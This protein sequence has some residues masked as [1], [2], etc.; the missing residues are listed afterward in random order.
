MDVL[1]V[2]P[3][4]PHNTGC[5]ARLAA[6]TGVA[7]HL[8]EPL[9]FSLEDRY[10]KRAGLDYWPMVELVVHASW[11]A[12]VAHFEVGRA[13]V[14]G[15]G[16][17]EVGGE[18]A[19]AEATGGHAA[20]ATPSTRPFLERLRLFTARG[21]E[22]LFDVDFA[23][24]DILCFGA[25]SKGLPADLLE[26]LANQRVY[27]PVRSEVRSLNLANVVA[28]GLY[29]A[30]ARAGVAMPDGDGTYVPHPERARDLFAADVAQQ[31]AGA[32]GAGSADVAHGADGAS[33]AS[34]VVRVDSGQGGLDAQR[35]AGA[36]PPSERGSA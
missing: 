18:A 13:D 26:G 8:V 1:L 11:E 29:T 27:V 23:A 19:G 5:A 33:T 2:N 35:G 32:D 22:P 20:R 6:A 31:G 30:M 3:E 12:C 21:G 16:H 7:L 24:D 17:G 34:D 14:S 15:G 36:A 25:E 9:G 4:I 10:L 28:L